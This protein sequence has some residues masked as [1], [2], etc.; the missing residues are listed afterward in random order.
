VVD[1][2]TKD[3]LLRVAFESLRKALNVPVDFAID[4]AQTKLALDLDIDAVLQMTVYGV[5]IRFCVVVK[6]DVNKAVIGRLLI[7]RTGLPHPLLFITNHT[8]AYIADILMQ[9]EIDFVDTAGNT[10]M[11]QPPLFVFIKGNRPSAAFRQVP[12]RRAL[13]PTGL[14]VAFAVLCNPNLL[15]RPYREIADTA[16]VALGSIGWII[17]DLKALGCVVDLG[18]RGLRLKQRQ[19]L[20][21]R[22]TTEYPEKLKPKLLLGTYRGSE[23]WWQHK[24]L[25]FEHAQ[26]GGEVGAGKLTHYLKPGE[27]TIY[28]RRI[29]LSKLLIENRLKKDADGD[30]EIL[31]RFWKP[32]GEK[33]YP[34]VVHPILIYSDLV[35]T[36]DQRNIETAKVILEKYI[37]RHIRED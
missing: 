27:I 5:K 18:K 7:L 19:K 23:D 28:T 21:N 30:V 9:N 33:R 20:F 25:D 24:D 29:H 11:K 14:K 35:A 3:E 1:R 6:S 4:D 37:V 13:N 32:I 16:G 31:E 15:N 22:W 10:Y 26:W 34:D 17:R 2:Y 8:T 12:R 36:G